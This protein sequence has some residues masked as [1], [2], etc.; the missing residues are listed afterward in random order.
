MPL[1]I[2]RD[3]EVL[4]AR[5]MQAGPANVTTTATPT[6]AAIALSDWPHAFDAP[7][8]APFDSSCDSPCSPPNRSELENA[9]AQDRHTHAGT[10]EPWS[11]AREGYSETDMVM[12]V[13]F[14]TL[15]ACA[16]GCLLLGCYVETH[17]WFG[18]C[19]ERRRHEER[20]K[21]N[22]ED[23]NLQRTYYHS[24]QG[25]TPPEKMSLGA[26]GP[27][28]DGKRKFGQDAME[29]SGVSPRSPQPV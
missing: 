21:H 6:D 12:V 26:G 25:G 11:H 23:S 4:A 7:R 20:L 1:R 27:L 8:A 17:D 13:V 16:I 28:G 3:L 5:L 15:V 22:S 9:T 18:S 10:E 14:A 2:A 29:S 24:E 19:M